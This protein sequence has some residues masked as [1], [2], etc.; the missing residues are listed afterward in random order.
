[1]K[2]SR[3]MCLRII[4][5]VTKKGFNLFLQDRFIEKHKWD[6]IDP[7]SRFRVNNN[8]QQDSRVLYTFVR[9][10]SSNIEW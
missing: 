10:K 8:Y 3:K 1:M 7:Q 9:N 5:K 2:F 6:Q 4:L